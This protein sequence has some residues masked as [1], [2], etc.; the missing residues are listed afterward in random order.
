M[1][2][3][4]IVE[5]ANTIQTNTWKVEQH[6]FYRGIP[7]PSFD[8]ETPLEI[9]LPDD[10]ATCRKAIL[11]ATDELHMLVL[12]PVQTEQCNPVLQAIYR[13]RIAFSF[14]VG[15]TATFAQIAK[16]CG[17]AEDEVKRIL[18]MAITYRLFKE[19]Q[20]GVVAHTAATKALVQRPLFNAWIGMWLEEM[21]ITLSRAFN[22]AH[23]TQL[24]VYEELSKHPERAVRFKDAMNYF[25]TAPGFEVTRVVDSFHWASIEQGTV[26]DVGGSHGVV[27]I[28]LARRFPS[29]R[30]VVQDRGEVISAARACTP[31]D[32]AERVDF[33]VNDFFEEQPVKNA[34]VYFFRWILH[35][36]S[37]KYCVKILRALISALKPGARVLIQDLLIPEAG[38]LS[39]FAERNV[40]YVKS[41]AHV[42]NH[43]VEANFEYSWTDLGM[44]AMENAKE[45]DR[46]D[47]TELLKEADP[48]FIL[49]CINTPVKSELSMVEVVWEDSTSPK[50]S[51]THG[52]SKHEDP[53][54]INGAA[55]AN[56]NSMTDVELLK[57]GPLDKHGKS[58]L[59]DRH[60]GNGVSDLPDAT[61]VNGSSSTHDLPTAN[62][63][64]NLAP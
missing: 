21:G 38:T 25:Q 42:H 62:L 32:V 37:D 15:E 63:E 13:F 19:P 60:A 48:R 55:M 54:L 39:P 1:T 12:G 16:T 3:S 61:E 7:S 10:I 53:Q 9:E 64:S 4:R 57:H 56:G 44:L 17:R 18:R 58:D 49:K 29:L 27:S 26:V 59:H 46:S 20:P 14:P 47:W 24:S 50:E 40:R 45:R 41:A 23:D 6:L 22:L 35:N 5:L 30:F 34:E 33:M 8:V 51:L 43:S 11:E 2:S 31:K 52:E 36:W 28:E